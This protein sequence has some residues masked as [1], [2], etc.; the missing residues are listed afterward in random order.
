MGSARTFLTYFI[1]G[2]TIVARADVAVLLLESTDAGMSRYTAAGHSAVYLSNVCQESP[3]KLRLC[4]EGEEGSVLSTYG[5]F[6]ETES[7][8]W[9]VTP[10]NVFLYGAEDTKD[11]PIYGDPEL[12]RALQERYRQ[13]YLRDV[14]PSTF[15]GAGQGRWRDLVGAT[16]A[17]DIYAFRVKTTREQDVALIDEF[18]TMP[19]VNRYNGFTHNCADFTRKL[20]NRYFQGSGR[21]DRLND[22]GI[23][24]PKAVAKS[25][26][27]YGKRHPELKYSVERYTQVAGSIPRSRDNRKGTEVIFRAKKWTMP[28]LIAGSP[29]FIYSAAAYYLTGRFNAEHEYETHWA[30]QDAGLTTDAAQ[31]AWDGYEGRFPALVAQAVR[32]GIFVQEK[33]VDGYFRLAARKGRTWLDAGGGPVLEVD[34][35]RTGLTRKTLVQP[36]SDPLVAERLMLARVSATLKAVPKNR[37][38]LGEFEKDWAILEDLGRSRAGGE[39]LAA[40]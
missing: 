22:F 25:F 29:F 30:R 10:V 1:F 15:C 9:N 3:V 14:C 2:S 28:L 4:R 36:G 6:G 39:T 7:F 37:E 13:K 23:T 8:D 33:D 5:D 12:R 38:S 26:A 18:N 16:F 17:R 20:V 31:E 32:D 35:A 34:G 27:N 24:S 21:A 19:N 40:R 11:I